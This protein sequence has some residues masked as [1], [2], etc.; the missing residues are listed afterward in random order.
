M[1]SKTFVKQ[2]VI[3]FSTFSCF[4]QGRLKAR[5]GGGGA[6]AASAGEGGSKTATIPPHVNI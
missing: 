3:D 4:R 2:S 1:S 6:R 5:A